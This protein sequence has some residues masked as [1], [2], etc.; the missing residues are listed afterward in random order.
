[1][2]SARFF[3]RTS[4]RQIINHDVLDKLASA[5][6]NHSVRPNDDRAPV[7]EPTVLALP[8][9]IGRYDP[10]PCPPR[11]GLKDFHGAHT[12]HLRLLGSEH[13][14]DR[15]ADQVGALPCELI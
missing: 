11:A 3:D 12:P 5:G 13:V 9:Y 4:L 7:A 1:M 6:S 8:G 2:H 10:A 14:V 15:G